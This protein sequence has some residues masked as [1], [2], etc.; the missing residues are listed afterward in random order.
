[1]ITVDDLCMEMATSGRSLTPRAARDWW[2]KGLLARPQ[3]RSLGSAGFET[4]WPC[5]RILAQAAAAYDLLAMHPRTD[6]VLVR[7]WLMGFS[8]DISRLRPAWLMLIERDERPVWGSAEI[9]RLPEDA[10]GEIA[11]SV[12][13]HMTRDRGAI[14]EHISTVASESLN[15][16]FGT[17]EEVEPYGLA[18]AAAAMMRHLHPELPGAGEFSWSDEECAWALGI[19]K[20]WCSLPAQR[21][22]VSSAAAHEFTRARRLLQIGIGT[23]GRKRE[24]LDLPGHVP[25]PLLVGRVAIPV[26]IKVLRQPYARQVV[27][28]ALDFSRRLR[29]QGAETVHAVY[30]PADVVATA[31]PVESAGDPISATAFRS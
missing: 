2:T 5:T 3:R 6:A 19:L 15:V 27:D 30:Q 25:L 17:A 13:S 22:T 9:G 29:R 24:R 31:R 7:L 14:F 12:V 16:F 23:F 4:Y 28:T 11:A 1:M 10:V 21:Q 8:V 18:E 20:E 26:L